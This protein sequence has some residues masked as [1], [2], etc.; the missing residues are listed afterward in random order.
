M[1]N[2]G[3]ESI[4][5]HIRPHTNIL[6]PLHC[7][8]AI[9]IN[10]GIKSIENRALCMIE[11][12]DLCMILC[13]SAIGGQTSDQLWSK[14][15]SG[16]TEMDNQQRFAV[17]NA[18]GWYERAIKKRHKKVK[19]KDSNLTAWYAYLQKHDW[20][21]FL[22]ETLPLPAAKSIRKWST[23][24]CPWAGETNKF[25]FTHEPYIKIL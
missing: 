23:K 9:I 6:I 18:K 12:R 2:Q 8:S 4:I 24:Q 3:F 15:S 13:N 1:K 11:N 5:I 25:K 14:R 20:N 21:F 22:S 19:S 7:N 10:K 17:Q 16:K